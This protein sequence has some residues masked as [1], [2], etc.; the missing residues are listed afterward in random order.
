MVRTTVL[1]AKPGNGGVADYA[2][3]LAD[4][5][6]DA[7]QETVSGTA[8][9]LY[10]VRLAVDLSR[11]DHDVINV[12]FVYGFFGPLGVWVPLFLAVLYGLT[13]RSETGVVLVV[14]EGWDEHIADG[15]RLRYAYIW[16]MNRTLAALSD[17]VVFLSEV[18]HRRILPR[19]PGVVIPHGVPVAKA[20]DGYPTAAKA[21]F[22]YDPD[23]FVVAQ[24]GFVNRRKNPGVFVEVARALPD[25][26]FLLAGGAR[27][28]EFE[29]LFE[30]VC[31]AAPENLQVTG[32]LD[33][34]AFQAA[35]AAADLVVLPYDDIIQSGIFNWCAAHGKP[36]VASD[37]DYF[38]HLA[39]EHDC[40]EVATER[41]Y[42]ETVERLCAD[43]DRRDELAANIER[44]ADR[45]AMSA[46]V[47]RYDD[48][49]REVAAEVTT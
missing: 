41:S 31:A 29:P 9:P 48:L 45:N 3:Q 25:R 27:T 12:Q 13:R 11:R 1:C 30:Q 18:G 6:P 47:E 42:R 8:N 49:H 37:I 44:Y 35:F 28:P 19:I 46:V 38:R 17:R 14:H 32:V 34:D 24:I 4:Q 39:T 15:S 22:G 33:G 20:E 2:D 23:T 16:L 10:Y 26:T 36:V 21:R 40:V 5:L 43:A 7:S